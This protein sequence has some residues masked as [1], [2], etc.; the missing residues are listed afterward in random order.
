MAEAGD[1]TSSRDLPGGR[2]ARLSISEPADVLSYIPHTLGFVPHESLVVLTLGNRSLGATLRL[3]LPG[4]GQP[5]PRGNRE[6]AAGVLRI[7]AAE[8]DARAVFLVL[9]THAPWTGPSR[10]P[11]RAL[12]RCLEKAL[13]GA[14]LPVREGWVVGPESWRGYFCTDPGCCPWPGWPLSAITDSTLNAELV[15]QGSSFDPSLDAAVL[16]SL[17]APPPDAG[18]A[19]RAAEQRFISALALHWQD[20]Q[21][22]TAT[23]AV[24]NVL[25]Q[26]SA[27]HA[28]GSL[29]SRPAVTGFLLASL[30]SR[31]VRDSLLVLAA[32][33]LD[34]ALAGARESGLFHPGGGPPVLPDGV[35]ASGGTMT[36]T[37]LGSGAG[38]RAAPVH[39]RAAGSP[40]ALFRSVLVAGSQE[41]PDWVRLD[42]AFRVLSELLSCAAGESEA[43]LLTLLAWIEWARGRGSRAH[44]FLGR[45]LNRYPSYRL[46]L[47]LRGLLD[48][49]A[50]P[51]WAR[52][53]SSAWP[54]PGTGQPGAA[55]PG[56]PQAGIRRAPGATPG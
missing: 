32:L 10:P 45:C 33:D 39:V 46:A 48:H 21:Q 28:A 29:Q 7:L 51:A 26:A 52:Y 2:P 6:F 50:L 27:D 16:R 8:A 54:G 38:G 11:H 22:F 25:I 31:A 23:L 19:A 34:A 17:P 42:T 5:D 12:V 13:A 9:Y 30:H 40:G 14:G 49:G 37:G 55:P 56:T 47:L 18:T 4:E 53:R 41:P 35:M 24:W 3:D 44:A 1:M 36:I 20:E 15:F 43:A